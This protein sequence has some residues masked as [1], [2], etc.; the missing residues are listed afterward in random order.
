MFVGQAGI[1]SES[2]LV[3][4]DTRD[5]ADFHFPCLVAR[6]SDYNF[7]IDL[8]VHGVIQSD[9]ASPRGHCL[10]K[11]GPDESVILAMQVQPSKHT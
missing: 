2:P 10:S 1:Q 4:R 11:G 5:L 6:G 7:V 9:L 8:P 3:R